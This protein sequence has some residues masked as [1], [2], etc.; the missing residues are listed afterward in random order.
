M[1]SERSG[2]LLHT[3][4]F[5]S[6]F[7]FSK[8]QRGE[9]KRRDFNDSVVTALE[10]EVSILK[11]LYG[12]SP[13]TA[14]EQKKR[15]RAVHQALAAVDDLTAS[16]L[17]AHAGLR[18]WDLREMIDVCRD[19]AWIAVDAMDVP[20]SGP[21]ATKATH[22]TIV[23]GKTLRKFKIDLNDEKKGPFVIAAGIVLE[24]F[25]IARADLR[26]NCR[27]AKQVIDNSTR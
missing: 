14:R 10:A 24:A 2:E 13:P 22:I 18:S 1:N 12:A 17:A 4:F 9:F 3:A 11:G 5:I 7:R 21:E 19:A 6:D 25:G 16:V 20:E 26:Y 8:E 27:Q 15:L 23:V